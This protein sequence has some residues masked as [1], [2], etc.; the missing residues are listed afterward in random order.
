MELDEADAEVTLDGVPT[1][2]TGAVR[3]YL[4]PPLEP[5]RYT[6]TVAA[7]WGKAGV[8]KEVPCRPGQVVTVRLL[9]PQEGD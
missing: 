8:V 1:T 6:Y 7:R 3:H 9:R 5:G 4:S 2:T